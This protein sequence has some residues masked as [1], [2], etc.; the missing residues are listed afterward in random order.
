MFHVL[1]CGGTRP[2]RTPSA[3]SDPRPGDPDHPERNTESDR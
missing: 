1:T 3:G 2:V